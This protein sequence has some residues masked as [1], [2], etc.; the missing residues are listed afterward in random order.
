MRL[1]TCQQYVKSYWYINHHHKNS[2]FFACRRDA[3][4]EIVIVY[5]LS[6]SFLDVNHFSSSKNT[7]RHYKQYHVHWPRIYITLQCVSNDILIWYDMI[8]NWCMHCFDVCTY[9][10]LNMCIFYLPQFTNTTYHWIHGIKDYNVIY[11]ISSPYHHHHHDHG[12]IFF[13][14]HTLLWNFHSRKIFI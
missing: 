9:N 3:L 7:K 13:S 6:L 4:Q 5:S 11:A 2:F 10:K 8:D 14:A 12:T 1:R